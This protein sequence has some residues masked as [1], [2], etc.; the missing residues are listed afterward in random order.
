M[1]K[2][3]PQVDV[4][5]TA[6]RLSSSEQLVEIDGSRLTTF[7]KKKQ[8]KYSPI[9]QTELFFK[10]SFYCRHIFASGFACRQSQL[11]QSSASRPI[12]NYICLY[13]VILLLSILICQK[14]NFACNIPL[15]DKASSSQTPLRT[16]F[17]HLLCAAELKPLMSPAD[18]QEDNVCISGRIQ[19]LNVVRT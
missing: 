2:G 3:R 11:S 10:L 17:V 14:A 18:T 13:C 12:C 6:D 15:G 8:F 1:V 4:Q 16:Q 5:G 19:M 7:K 9:N